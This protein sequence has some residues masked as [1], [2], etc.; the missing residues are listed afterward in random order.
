MG[1]S[2]MLGGAKKWAVR[3]GYPP[4]GGGVELLPEKCPFFV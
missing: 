2:N 1:G 3:R 4:A